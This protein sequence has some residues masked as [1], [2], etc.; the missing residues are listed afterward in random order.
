M[1]MAAAN[2][3]TGRKMFDAPSLAEVID[4]YKKHVG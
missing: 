3:L 1:Y 2:E 4:K